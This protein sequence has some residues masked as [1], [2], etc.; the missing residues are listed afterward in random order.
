MD[1]NFAL[2]ECYGLTPTWVEE[3][4]HQERNPVSQRGVQNSLSVVLTPRRHTPSG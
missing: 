1:N 2:V 4:L 3:F